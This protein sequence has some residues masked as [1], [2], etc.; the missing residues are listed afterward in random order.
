MDF[1]HLSIGKFIHRFIETGCV[2]H[3]TAPER[4]DHNHVT[5]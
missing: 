2:N 1:G 5:I 4:L 3:T